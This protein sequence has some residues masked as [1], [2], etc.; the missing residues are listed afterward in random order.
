MGMVWGGLD[1]CSS[2]SSV[3][4][5]PTPLFATLSYLSLLT[6]FIPP[7]SNQ[8]IFQISLLVIV[9]SPSSLS[10]GVVQTRLLGPHL[11]P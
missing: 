8:N 1:L 3:I 6:P 7:P 10:L 11:L 4:L 5:M 2:V 9:S